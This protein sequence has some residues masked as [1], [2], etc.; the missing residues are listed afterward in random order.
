MWK[1]DVSFPPHIRWIVLAKVSSD[2]QWKYEFCKDIFSQILE[3]TQTAEAPSYETILEL[4]RKVREKILPPHLNKFTSPDDDE[5]TP[6]SYMH[7]CLLG[8][9]RTIGKWLCLRAILLFLTSFEALVYIHRSFFAQ[10][11]LDHPINPLRSPY[12]PSFLAAYRCASGIIKTSLNYN[13]RFPE[14]CGRLWG[15]W[16][17]CKLHVSVSSMCN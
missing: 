16:T 17:H 11:M 2:Y 5:I 15:I 3:Q 12:A 8:Q 9:F 6:S 1:W 4:D 10:A 7:G 13:E 14:L